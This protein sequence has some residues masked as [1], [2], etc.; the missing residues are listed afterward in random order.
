MEHT[1]H[2]KLSVLAGAA[3]AAGLAGG[4]AIG[5]RRKPSALQHL[6]REIGSAGRS[7]GQLQTDLH[8]VREQAEETHKQSPVEVLLSALTSRRLPKHG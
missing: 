1:D 3:A 6:A 5:A 2:V 4:V 8:A 7:L